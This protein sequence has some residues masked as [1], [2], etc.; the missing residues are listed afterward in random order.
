MNMWTIFGFIL[1]LLPT[2]VQA[3]PASLTFQGRIVGSSGAPL[4]YTN[5]SFLFQITDPT[6][7]CVLYQ[8]Q[9]NGYNMQNSGGVFDVAIG[10][11]S[12]QYPLSGT[13]TVL[14]TFA[15]SGTFAC[16]GC[17]LSGGV[18]SCTDSG[19]T[20]SPSVDDARKLRVSFF[21]GFAWRTISPDSVI[22]SVPFA[23]YAKSSEKLGTHSPS[24][25]LLK[26]GLPTCAAG[27]FLSYN[28]TSLTCA[29]VS[30]AS[31]GTVT[32][33]ATGTGL[34]G[35]PITT[36]G[37]I[38]L[39]NTAVTAG[40]YG[41]ASQIPTFT[42]DAQGRLTSAS[43][44]ALSVSSSQISDLSTTLSAYLTTSTF[45]GYISSAN[46]TASQ[47]MYWNSVSSKFLC[48]SI[49]IDANQ[50]TTGTI[51][52]ILLG[53]GIADS[54]TFLR[55]DGTWSTPSGGMSGTGTANYLPKFTGAT[56]LG[57]SLIYDNGTNVGI[58]TASPSEKLE[59]SGNI[60]ATQ[61][62]I[63]AD[64]RSAWPSSSGGTVTNITAGTGLNV[65]AGPGGSINSTGTL[66]VNV[67]SGANQIVQLNGSSQLPAVDGSLLTNLNPA[68]LSVIVPI[69]KGGTGQSTQTAA[70]NALSPLTAK[71]D[72]LV[73]DSTNNIRLPA[74]A[75]F[76]YL[77]AN[78]S[79]TSG[80]E[81]G[82][83][84]ATDISS[85]SSTGI[86][87]RTGAGAYTALGV[88][89][90]LIDTGTNIGLSIGNG[91]TTSAGSLVVDAGTGANQIPQLDGS[92]KLNSS[93]LPSGF[94][95]QWTTAG[96]KIFYNTGSVGVGTTNPTGKLDVVGSDP[97]DVYLNLQNTNASGVSILSLNNDLGQ[98]AKVFVNGSTNS[99]SAGTNSLNI[100]TIMNSPISF[101]TNN[102]ERMRM[103]ADGNIGVGTTASVSK[104]H[105]D[106]GRNGSSAT[107]SWPFA[108]NNGQNNVNPA[109]VSS[110]YNVGTN[111]GAALAAR[112]TGFDGSTSGTFDTF[113]GARAS[114]VTTFPSSEYY[115]IV[116]YDNVNSR[117]NYS[118]DSA[119]KA[120]FRSNVGIGQVNPSYTLDV[121]GD[122]NVTGNF[123]VNGTNIGGSVAGSNGQ[124]Q[125]NNSSSFGATSKLHWN[126]TSNTL[127]IGGVP[128]PGGS[129]HISSPN[130]GAGG[131][132]R[133]V[134]LLT[135]WWSSASDARGGAIYSYGSASDQLVF[136][137]SGDG[138]ATTSPAV[139]SNAKM[140]IQANGRVGIGTTSPSYKF[141]VVGS[142]GQ[143]IGYFS[144]GS[145][146]CSITPSTAGS[147][148]C[149]SDERLK[150][151]VRS[152]SDKVSL[153]NI[154]K[155][156]TVTYDWKHIDD[157]RHTGYIAQE[158]EKIAPEFVVTGQDGF[159]Q[160][161]YT[162]FIPW[163]TGAIKEIYAK[164]LHHEEQLQTQERRIASIEDFK[165]E[166][167]AKLQF[168]EE[169]NSQLKK[170]NAE[171]KARLGKIETLMNSK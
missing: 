57:N 91:L 128:S 138:G 165:T 107:W 37:T 84:S 58:G 136:G 146:S 6:G 131:V 141:H 98:V 43:Q 36:T 90:P 60:K 50:I 38:S 110:F 12:M 17:T 93:V 39:A 51:A 139:Y 16:G 135:R 1:L 137:V 121:T 68:N 45:N 149:S 105:V 124:I 66:S 163:I 152:F 2:S 85:L 126:N 3:A 106:D 82:D 48:A 33:I 127:S 156:R 24:D 116:G 4:E 32:N 88:Q 9:V 89:A 114:N 80:L 75:D 125:F 15:N 118:V 67:G 53:S 78:S 94:G 31:G 11:G 64:C 87:K 92:G 8:E 148:T 59:V 102:T 86:V 5:V 22:R 13:F 28:G 150:R 170:D 74:G 133:S 79:R 35:G 108:S 115:H 72:L 49:S 140:V 109:L 159:K 130:D 153:E 154:L 168:F 104:L 76:K 96:N 34:S 41:S 164:F 122:V 119:G 97:A 95:S 132:E 81:Y 83:V 71:G 7:A 44:N 160:V 65:G 111:T 46:C 70:F 23:A 129:F 161:S 27:T 143:T 167:V 134:L 117:L 26:A 29:A 171:I 77:R 10:K 63:G 113:L 54:T 166:M 169:E 145:A 62:C 151:N 101:I 19:T 14:D 158:V 144:D 42:V 18:Y 120:Y 40:T 21:D 100:G 47:T 73:R 103:T 20:F 25:F 162:A 147:V 56:T 155:L 123:K 52:T 69:S 61:V 30:G 55:G 112:V 99:D 157:G 142:S